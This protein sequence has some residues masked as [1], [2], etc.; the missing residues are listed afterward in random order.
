[1]QMSVRLFLLLLL[2]VSASTRDDTRLGLNESPPWRV[3][4]PDSKGSEMAISLEMISI[5]SL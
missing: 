4:A 3:N 5:N 1:V 2:P